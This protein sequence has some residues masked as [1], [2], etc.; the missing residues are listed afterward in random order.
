MTRLSAWLLIAACVTSWPAD[1]ASADTEPADADSTEAKAAPAEPKNE[2]WG[3]YDPGTGFLVAR[4]EY[5]E[6]AFSGYGLLRYINQMPGSQTWT[7]HLGNKR[8]TDGRQDLYPHRIMIWLKG[9]MWD[10]KLIYMFTLWTVNT[11]DQDAL[12]ANIGYQFHR[13]FNLYAGLA[14][15]CGT[16]SILGSHPYWL[17][18]DRVM[19]DEFFR[20]FFGAGLY[21]NGELFHGLWYNAMVTNSNSILGVKASDLDRKPTPS[22]SIWYMPTGEFGPRG[23]Y[24]DYENHQE[25]AMR[26]GASACYSPEQSFAGTGTS[27]N[28]TLKLADGV[29]V[30]DPGALAG[31]VTVGN[32]DYRVLAIDAGVKYRGFFL[33]AEHYIRQLDRFA[34]DGPLP[35]SEILDQ[36]FYVQ[37]ACFPVPKRV[38]LY[39]ATSQIYGDKD[40]GFDNSNEYVFGANLYPFP[41]RDTRL[42]IQ[43]FA[44]NHSPVGSTFGYYTAGQTGS[45]VAVAY[46]LMF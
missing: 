12:F 6:L 16:R 37:A 19:A 3:T 11:T 30:F 17:G 33:Q 34:A 44:V 2:T 39:A 25:V 38:E 13:K 31:G 22:A 24:G 26:F 36:G 28:T 27:T 43:Y 8:Q 15:N 40:A 9:W 23:A 4:T 42:N 32:L 21:A 35:V 46:S 5:G 41:T 7:D 10:P 45:T 14:G 20:P 1:A 29:N 18:H